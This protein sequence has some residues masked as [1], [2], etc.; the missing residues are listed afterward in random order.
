M[1]KRLLAEMFKQ[2]LSFNPGLNEEKVTREDVLAELFVIL[3]CFD[4]GRSLAKRF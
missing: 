2:V 4:C 1:N 3:R